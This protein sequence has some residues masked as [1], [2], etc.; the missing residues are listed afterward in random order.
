MLDIFEKYKNKTAV[1][2][3]GKPYTY[4]DIKKLIASQIETLKSKKNNIVILSG[5]NFNF[6]I[7]F[8]ASIYCGKN[9]YLITDR[10]R[11]KN[12]EC[13][14]D[15]LQNIEEKYINDYKFPKIDTKKG[16]INFFTSGSTGKPKNIKKSLFNL[17]REAH[18]IGKTFNFEGK[19]YI[20]K[21]TT[22]MCHLFGTTFHLMTSLYNGLT[23]DTDEISYPENVDGDNTILVSTPTFLVS[24]AK[25]E[26]GF[27]KPPKYIISAGSKLD[28]TVFKI[29]EETSKIIEIYGSSETGV[30]ANKT[31]FC[32]DFRIFDNVKINAFEDFVEV[33]SDYVF[34]GKTKINDKIEVQQGC[35][36]FKTRTDRL[37]KI[38]EKRISAD[39]LE[40]KLNKNDYVNE[41]YITKNKD[42]LVCLCALSNSGKDYVL[43]NGVF[44]LTKNLKQYLLKHSEIVP[45]RWK[46]INEIPRNIMGKI[47]K[48]FI[49]HI[50][51]IN[52]S[53]PLILDKKVGKNCVEYKLFLYNQCN[54]FKGHFP[55]FKLTPG[56]IQLYW[57]KEFANAYFNLELG[58]GQ[59][60]RIKFSKIIKPDSIINLKLEKSEK[61]VSYEYY[62]EDKKYAS[63]AFLCENVFK[64][65]WSNK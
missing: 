61:S 22:T 48:N 13:D 64:D 29:L 20:V 26:L 49:D 55:E 27:K 34:D 46:Y 44:E 63:G 25:F 50:F 7:Q 59:W 53:T 43:K 31:H 15:I 62:F 51:N 52:V 19:N 18:D 38:Y 42:K 8:F 45:Q 54:F 41:S 9:I 37:F 2:K 65:L 56:V 11:L 16:S 39:E 60:K 1:L 17:I 28:E 10:T 40:N 58:E 57:A 36:K 47:N 6:I 32:S 30:I 35:I 5:D 23:I 24:A 3:D 21:S 12:L 14:F 4:N 33:I